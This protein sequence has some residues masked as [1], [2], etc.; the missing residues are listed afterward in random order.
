LGDPAEGGVLAHGVWEN[1]GEGADADKAASAQTRWSTPRQGSKLSTVI[2]LPVLLR[3]D[4][5]SRCGGFLD[6]AANMA[7][8][9]CAFHGEGKNSDLAAL[10]HPGA[11]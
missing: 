8:P 1:L 11:R 9:V 4:A 5:I 3:D 2:D 7:R 6:H 10:K